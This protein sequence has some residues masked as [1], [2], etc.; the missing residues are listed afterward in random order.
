[1]KRWEFLWA[2]FFS[3]FCT[4]DVDIPPVR[5]SV[6]Q[7]LRCTYRYG[8]ELFESGGFPRSCLHIV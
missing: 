6:M 5:I 1:M 8:W 7:W 3:T 4:I 2:H